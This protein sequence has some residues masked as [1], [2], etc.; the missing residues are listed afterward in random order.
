MKGDYIPLV[1]GLLVFLASII[2]LRLGLS[3]AIIEIALGAIAGNLGLHTEEWMLYIA[4][5]GGIILTYLAGTEIDTKLFKEKFKESFL[6]GFFS[7]LAPFVAAFLFTY[8]F[9][10]WGYKP[11]LIAGI[12]LSTT[13]LAVV[14]SVLVETGLTKT[15]IGKLLMAATFV[16][17]MGTALALS[18]MFIQPTLFTLVFYV[19]SILI[20][21]FVDRFS[22]YILNHPIYFNK[23]IEPEIKFI[24]LVLLIFIFFAQL[25]GGQAILPAFI[26]GLIMSKHF[27]EKKK[28]RVVLNRLRTVA[29]AFITPIF[30]IVGGMKISAT[31]IIASLGLFAALFAVKIIAKFIGVYF[32][33]KKYISGGSMYTTLLMSTGLTFGTISS[34]FG[35]QAGIINQ[36]QYSI[37]VGAVVASAIIPTFIAQKWFMPV[38]E[39]DILDFDTWYMPANDDE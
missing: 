37:L 5:F 6:I 2:S 3:V 4:Q 23:V 34:L 29:Y 39:E 22:P 16:T 21:L 36:T 31:M 15:Q 13:S 1:V 28:T 20:I 38:D 14:Y 35:L 9:A 18:I 27:D 19:G 30:F 26:L 33:A 10:G 12:A 11:S 25:G 32:L 17:D 8:Y 7:F 24:F